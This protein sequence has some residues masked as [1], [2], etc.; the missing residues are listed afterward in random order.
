MNR[1]G[2]LGPG[3]FDNDV[4]SDVKN[5]FE[6]ALDEGLGIH[7]ASQRVLEEFAEDVEDDDDGPLIYLAL[8]GLQMQC[9]NLHP[10][11]RAKALAILDAGRGLELWEGSR[12]VAERQQVLEQFRL[13]LS[14]FPPPPETPR[15]LPPRPPK[16]SFGPGDL[17]CIPLPEGRM[18]F[19]RVLNDGAF[20]VYDVVSDHQE[21]PEELRHH[22]YIFRIVLSNSAI[23]SW[24]WS[25]VR[26]LDFDAAEA[27]EADVAF[28]VTDVLNAAHHQI[29]FRG[30]MRPATAEEWAGLEPL[31]VYEA[32]HVEERILHELLTPPEART[33][34]RSSTEDMFALIKAAQEHKAGL[35]TPERVSTAHSPDDQIA[36]LRAH[37]EEALSREVREALELVYMWHEETAEPR[38]FFQLESLGGRVRC[39]LWFSN[40]ERRWQVFIPNPYYPRLTAEES[41]LESELLAAIKAFGELEGI[42]PL[43][44]ITNLQSSR[45]YEKPRKESEF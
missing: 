23:S 8:A 4:A 9:G 18:A 37:L 12:N 45:D 43:P 11:M 33:P 44:S 36:W 6:A 30:E 22:P 26:H 5:V 25:V 35:Q 15:P 3:I 27:Q 2:Y 24:R 19:G 7:Q 40:R 17:V 39:S 42:A 34:W 31:E 32:E 1:R 14:T 38:A 13:L 21:D 41:E 16:Q 28:Q 29:S 20:G 10:E